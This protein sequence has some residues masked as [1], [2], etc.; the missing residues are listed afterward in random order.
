M[1]DSLILKIESL[2]KKIDTDV[3][4]AWEAFELFVEKEIGFEKKEVAND[5]NPAS[6][7]P[8]LPPEA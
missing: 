5:A 4:T 7:N 3:H 8:T 6:A 1:F 2:A